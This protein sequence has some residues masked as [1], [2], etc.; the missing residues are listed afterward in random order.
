M[1]RT[2][3]TGGKEARNVRRASEGSGDRRGPVL[4]RS[5]GGATCNRGG[6]AARRRKL[7]KTKGKL[8]EGRR[9]RRDSGKDGVRVRDN[10]VTAQA[11]IRFGWILHRLQIVSYRD[12]R[13]QNQNEH[14]ERNELRTPVGASVPGVPQPYAEKYDG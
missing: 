11:A 9:N 1:V 5:E 4:N 3:D 2:A 10:V 12:H 8:R 13:E 14:R 7:Q 6:Q